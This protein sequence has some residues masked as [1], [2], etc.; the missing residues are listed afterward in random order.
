LSVLGVVTGTLVDSE[1]NPE[2]V[3][4]GGHITLV[5]GNVTLRTSTDAAGAYRFDGVPE[6][7]FHIS[8][9]DFDSGRSTSSLDF[10]LTG[11]GRIAIYY[12]LQ[13]HIHY[14]GVKGALGYWATPSG[15]EVDFVWWYGRNI[16]AIEVK[17]AREFRRE[18]K[19]GIDAF[20]A[21]SPAKS[22]I[23]YRG[24]RELEIDGTRV[25]PLDTFLRRLHA[26]EIVG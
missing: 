21:G 15:S 7:H 3:I 12:D 25:L 1:T 26:G 8:G 24:T 13:S 16:V 11:G 9:F 18:W 2:R 22:Y 20:R 19:K 23:V 10:V 5:S 14:A 6:G 4:A 17:S